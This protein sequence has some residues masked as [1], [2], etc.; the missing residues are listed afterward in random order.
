MNLTKIHGLHPLPFH[1]SQTTV[2]QPSLFFP[3]LSLPP[4]HKPKL[5]LS[6][7]TLSS[8]SPTSPSKP[9]FMSRH[10][11]TLRV[12]A[13]SW[14]SE[15]ERSTDDTSTYFEDL[16]PDGE[17]YRKT[18]RLVECSMFAALGGLAYLLSSSLAI[19]VIFQ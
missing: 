1:I 12:D 11:R 10:V 16:T 13:L 14:E 18:L 9:R 2:S 17:V 6:T 15:G 8:K 3:H 5:S 7:S 4:T 19:E